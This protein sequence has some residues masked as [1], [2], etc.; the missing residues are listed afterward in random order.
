MIQ[1]WHTLGAI[2]HTPLLTYALVK[3]AKYITSIHIT[4]AIRATCIIAYPNPNHSIRQLLHKISSYSGRVF[5]CLALHRA[6][7]HSESI[8]YRLRWH[9]DTVK[10]CIREPPF[11]IEPYTVKVIAEIYALSSNLSNT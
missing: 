2:P 9:I 8:V 3:T 10:K 7:S 5:V 1:R 11:D 6:G 4:V